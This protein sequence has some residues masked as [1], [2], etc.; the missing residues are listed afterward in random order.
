MHL[1]RSSCDPCSPTKTFSTYD[2]CN[3]YDISDI[4]DIFYNHY[5]F[6]YGPII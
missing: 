3:N 2:I 6:C 4:H 1:V 5:N